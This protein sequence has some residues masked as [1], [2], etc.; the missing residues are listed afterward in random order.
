MNEIVPMYQF[1][2]ILVRFYQGSEGVQLYQ[3][4]L[5][6]KF[7]LISVE[8]GGV[9][10]NQFFPKFKIVHIILGG[11]AKKIMDFF[12]NLWDFYFGM[13]PLIGTYKIKNRKIDQSW[14]DHA[15]ALFCWD[16][17]MN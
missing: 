4:S 10:E 7:F 2:V 8:G 6:F 11:G 9:V 13:P 15:V 14:A 17:V 1:D 16:M 5:H 12:H 3:N